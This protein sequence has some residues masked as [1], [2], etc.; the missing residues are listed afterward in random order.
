MLE[1]R[2]AGGA[3]LRRLVGA[4]LLDGGTDCALVARFL[5]FAGALG[6]AEVWLRAAS[7]SRKSATAISTTSHT[8]R[9]CSK[10]YRSSFSAVFG[11]KYTVFRTCCSPERLRCTSD[12]AGGGGRRAAIRAPYN[13][14]WPQVDS[15]LVSMSALNT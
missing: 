11:R 15:V 13:S 4:G 5:G 3:E 10:A 7:L 2:D 6:G 9:R 8:R 14:V 1:G 12:G